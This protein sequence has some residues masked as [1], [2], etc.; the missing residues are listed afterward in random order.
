MQN[1]FVDGSAR[2][3]CS[4]GFILFRQNLLCDVILIADEIEIPAHK[5]I[6]A[7]CS[8]YFYAMFTGFE[9]SRQSRINILGEQYKL[10]KQWVIVKITTYTLCN[11]LGHLIMFVSNFHIPARLFTQFCNISRTIFNE[12]FVP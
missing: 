1:F 8:P 10:T 3:C 2:T 12:I 5:M 11:Y 6:L 4:F 9:E 7:S